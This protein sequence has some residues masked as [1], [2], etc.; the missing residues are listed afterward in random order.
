ML[1]GIFA[2]LVAYWWFS[3][4]PY[5]RPAAIVWN[6]FGMAGLINAVALGTLT[7]GGG[8]GIVFPIVLIP[9]YAVPRVFLIYSY[10]QI[11]LFRKNSRPQK[12]VEALHNGAAA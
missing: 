6:L 9:V 12:P 1:T 7:G 8:G 4:K 11:G 3:A 10:S 2:P 5:A